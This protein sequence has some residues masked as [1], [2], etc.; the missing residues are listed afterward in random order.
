M[1][2]KKSIGI[3]SE[4]ILLVAITYFL[5]MSL[6]ISDFYQVVEYLIGLLLINLGYN[7]LLKNKKDKLGIIEIVVGVFELV[8]VIVL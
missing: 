5:I 3:I 4:A 7:S 8:T 1:N 2:N 6:V